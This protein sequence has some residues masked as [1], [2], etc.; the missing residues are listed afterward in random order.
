MLLQMVLFHSFN[1]GYYSI[2]WLLFL[3]LALGM[4]KFLGRGSNLSHNSDNVGS[5]TIRP[6]GNS[7]TFNT[8]NYTREKKYVKYYYQVICKQ[9]IFELQGGN[10]TQG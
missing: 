1:T 5:L 3:G 4:Q 8:D 9:T 6:P 7:I 2:V 10:G